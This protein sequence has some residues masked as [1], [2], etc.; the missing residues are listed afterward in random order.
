M[1]ADVNPVSGGEK[2]LNSLF[3]FSPCFIGS[4][5]KNRC[6][7]VKTCKTLNQNI[8]EKEKKK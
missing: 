6:P 7:H 1:R 8:I 3:A 5:L 4:W 2:L